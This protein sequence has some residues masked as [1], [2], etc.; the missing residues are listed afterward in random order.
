MYAARLSLASRPIVSNY[1]ILFEN[2]YF[3]ILKITIDKNKIA[4]EGTIFPK[5]LF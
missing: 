2:Y 1:E 4:F 5:N 3:Y